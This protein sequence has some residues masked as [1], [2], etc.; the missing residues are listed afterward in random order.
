MK[1]T[2]SD[3]QVAATFRTLNGGRAPEHNWNLGVYASWAILLLLAVCF[4]AV[5]A[6]VSDSDRKAEQVRLQQSADAVLHSAQSRMAGT[7]EMLQRASMR[8]MHVPGVTGRVESAEM[9]AAGLMQARGEVIEIAI[10]DRNL[11]VFRHW[12]SP[13]EGLAAGQPLA[14]EVT[15]KEDRLAVTEAFERDA[16]V[17]TS[18]WSRDGTQA[19]VDIALPTPAP[20]LVLLARINL[21]RVI[22]EAVLAS[23]NSRYRY[24]LARDGEPIACGTPAKA[25]TRTIVYT[26]G[27]PFL[28]DP[29]IT[30]MAQSNEHALIAPDSIKFWVILSLAGL[31]LLSLAMLIVYQRRQTTAHELLA[32]EYALRVA[33]SDSSIAGLHVI[34]AKGTLLYMNETFL[35]MVGWSAD[36]LLGMR[37]PY[38]FWNEDLSERLAEI[39]RHPEDRSTKTIECG[40]RRKDGVTF[41]GQVNISPLVARDRVIGWMAE[42]YDITEQKRARERMKAAHDRFTRVVHSMNSAICVISCDSEAPLLLFNNQPYERFFGPRVDG[43]LRLLKLIRSQK[44]PLQARQGVFDEA[45]GRWFD[46][47]QQPLTWI[48]DSKAVMIIATDITAQRE[49]EIAL[50]EQERRAETQQRLVTMGEMASSLAHELNQPLA[51]ISNYASGAGMMLQ[52]GKLSSEAAQEAF[53]KVDKQAR[54][55]AA[56][57]KRIRGFAAAKKTE[58]QFSALAPETV[59]SET[60]EL[61]LIQAAKL[62]AKISTAIEPNLPKVNGDS[63]ML[64]QLLLNLLKNAMEAV[65]DCDN[66][67][68]EL[69]VKKAEDGGSVLFRIADH[70]PGIEDSVKSKL[71]DAFYST[72]TT[73]M[74]MGLNICRSIM[75]I[76]H[77]RILISDTPGGGATFTFTVPV[78]RDDAQ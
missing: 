37:M 26:R 5:A 24:C 4:A 33:I 7:S 29:S 42:L 62:D 18:P 9:A 50:E 70:G 64:E 67:T 49:A 52:A 16:P 31:L 39:L 23:G 53:A 43:A 25:D 73:G 21:T 1:Q 35:K 14:D 63:V 34:D 30:F 48:D 74:G 2:I 78:A 41:D 57:I 38:L 56:I 10:V 47:R 66:R 72:K 11:H 40:F 77:G 65:Q 76:H 61:A 46:A 69:T 32:A 54:R 13:Y 6:F 8:L 15:G 22:S 75:E 36:E 51:A 55:A 12:N 3:E 45:S 60:M 27:V 71:F 28:H 19:L 59:V 68:V 44:N 58:P 17:T 20:S